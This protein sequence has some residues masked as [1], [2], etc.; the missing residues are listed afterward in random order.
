MYE[1]SFWSHEDSD[2]FCQ[3]S[4]ISEV[5]ALPDRLYRRREHGKNLTA[6][7]VS[8]ARWTED[9]FRSKWD[10]YD[11][12]HPETAEI[13]GPA[14][15][16]YYRRHAPLRDFKVALMTLKILVRKP[17]MKGLKWMLELI[18]SGITGLVIG[19]RRLKPR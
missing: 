15:R 10:F 19:E 3:M 13:I 8:S 9:K 17:T 12:A 5:H 4:L 16:Y 6:T 7:L 1:E 18:G 2:I 11:R 14:R